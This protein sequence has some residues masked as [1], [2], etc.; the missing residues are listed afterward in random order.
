MRMGVLQCFGLLCRNRFGSA[1]SQLPSVPI[2]R[3]AAVAECDRLQPGQPVATAS[4]A[5][6]DW[7]LVANELAAAAG[8]DGRSAGETCALLLAL[9]GRRTSDSEAVRQHA[10]NDRDVA[11][12]GR[13]ANQDRKQ[14]SARKPSSG[15]VSATR[16]TGA[17]KTS[18]AGPQNGQNE[19]HYHPSLPMISLHWP[20]WRCVCWPS[21][22]RGQTEPYGS[23]RPCGQASDGAG[24][25]RALLYLRCPIIFPKT[26]DGEHEAAWAVLRPV[27]QLVE[28]N[29]QCPC[30]LFDGL[31]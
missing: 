26:S 16:Q 22:A 27:E 9:A 11:A 24:L 19:P 10:E 6:E 7:E 15:E 14:T 30:Q 18:T 2:E 17:G 23:A 5:E 1:S 20:K 12:A 13:L 21:L 31:D 28:V 8:E 25:T 3:G 4:V 29:F